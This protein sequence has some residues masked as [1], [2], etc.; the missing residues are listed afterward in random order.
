MR[1]PLQTQERIIVTRM[2]ALL[3]DV[4][5]RLLI[6]FN[7]N[8]YYYSNWHTHIRTIYLSTLQ[9][10][11]IRLNVLTSVVAP[12]LFNIKTIFTRAHVCF[13]IQLLSFQDD[14]SHE[15]WINIFIYDKWFTKIRAYLVGWTLQKSV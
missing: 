15:L 12:V 7:W 9:K 8:L 3:T 13:Y 6:F 2:M 4:Q 14:H 1:L 10:E 11:E 5:W